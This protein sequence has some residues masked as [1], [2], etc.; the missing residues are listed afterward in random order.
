MLQINLLHH[1]PL[2]PGPFIPSTSAPTDLERHRQ[3]DHGDEA[4]EKRELFSNV[5]LHGQ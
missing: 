1:T 2:Q 3:D 5:V 4:A